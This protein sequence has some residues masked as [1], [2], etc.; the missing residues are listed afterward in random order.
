MKFSRSRHQLS[1][2]VVLLLSF[3]AGCSLVPGSH[4]PL[5]LN[6][7]NYP[8]DIEQHAAIY[9]ITPALI[10]QLKKASVQ[11][12]RVAQLTAE[13]SSTYDYRVQPGDVLNITVWDHPELTIPAGGE[14]SAREAGNWVHADGTIFYPYI[15]EVKVAG[16][17]VTEI[18]EILRER[19]ADYIQSPQVDVTIA[20]FRSQSVYVT[21]EVQRPGM[22]PITNVPLTL[23]GATAQA[24]GVTDEADWTNVSVTRDGHTT[25][26][27]LRDLYQRG[28]ISQN[29]QLRPNDIVHV[30][31]A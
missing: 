3:T 9:P 29:V 13:Q 31:H 25:S 5:S 17:G 19:L 2:G 7:Q 15:G 22:Q 30:A 23:L 1:W 10:G 16:L 26:Y 24:G 8:I 4:I 12:P 28:R 21:G 20:A 14:R 11:S 6:D 18:R 27:S